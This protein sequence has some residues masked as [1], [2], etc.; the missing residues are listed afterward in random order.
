[1]AGPKI[2]LMDN[3]L[4]NKIFPQRG[5]K[6]HLS[7][8]IEVGFNQYGPTLALS[9]SLMALS[10]VIFVH[11]IALYIY[12][13]KEKTEHHFNWFA[14]RPHKF[15]AGGYKQ[16]ELE[17]PSKFMI[18]VDKPHDYNILFFDQERYAYINPYLKRIKDYW[19]TALSNNALSANPYNAP[20]LVK[21]FLAD[22]WTKNAVEQISKMM[23]WKPGEYLV[24]IL[25][26][27]Q[28]FHQPFEVNR[29]F[30]LSGTDVG[31]FEQNIGMIVHEICKQP[32]I[33]Y[34][35]AYSPLVE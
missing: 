13:K 5:L 20:S 31:G 1:M 8:T 12:N 9:G 26:S 35:Y 21:S 7:N 17:M 3:P 11:N 33:F 28:N 22:R 25:V 16:I 10:K 15:A 24:K 27:T 34:H 6:S 32:N 4:F 18:T 30:T 19:S 2:E 14:F 29:S 23:Y